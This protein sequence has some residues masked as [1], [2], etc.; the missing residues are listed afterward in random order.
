MLLQQ[1]VISPEGFMEQGLMDIGFNEVCV[2]IVARSNKATADV[3]EKVVCLLTGMGLFAEAALTSKTTGGQLILCT[4]GSVD[5]V[6]LAVEDAPKGWDL[7]LAPVPDRTTG[8]PITSVTVV[9]KA[10]QVQT[11]KAP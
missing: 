3:G 5:D 1:P 6:R 7:G 4:D 9:S 2:N 10:K 8:Q 11:P